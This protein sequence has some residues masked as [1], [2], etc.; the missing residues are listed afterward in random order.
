MSKHQFADIHDSETLGLI[1]SFALFDHLISSSASHKTSSRCSRIIK[2]FFYD[3]YARLRNEKQDL[4]SGSYWE[5]CVHAC[6]F[7]INIFMLV[8]SEMHE[9]GQ[10]HTCFTISS[11][12]RPKKYVKNS[13]AHCAMCPII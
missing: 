11:N 13:E 7:V 9:H 4:Y 10:D 3:F 8:A 1:L 5:T 12:Q 6:A 2:Q